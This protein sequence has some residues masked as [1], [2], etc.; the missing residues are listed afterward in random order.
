MNE[1]L[2]IDDVKGFVEDLAQSG[3]FY[4]IFIGSMEW[5]YVLHQIAETYFGNDPSASTDFGVVVSEGPPVYWIKKDRVPL[6][7]IARRLGIAPEMLASARM[8][9]LPLLGG[10]D[11][12]QPNVGYYGTA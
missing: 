4:I 3:A 2:Q 8:V 12:P 9:E 5:H 11:Q 1:G 10:E 6:D 7:D